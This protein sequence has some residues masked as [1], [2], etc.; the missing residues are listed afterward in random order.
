MTWCFW[1]PWIHIIWPGGRADKL[2]V[3]Y[4]LCLGVVSIS[5]CIITCKVVNRDWY[6]HFSWV[7]TSLAYCYR[8]S[9]NTGMQI[10]FFG[11]NLTLH[12]NLVHSIFWNKFQKQRYK[13]TIHLDYHVF[14]NAKYYFPYFMI[15]ILPS[16][17]CLDALEVLSWLESVSLVHL[18]SCKPV[19]F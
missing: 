18:I 15:L 11:S 19:F 16:G 2:H 1:Q 5:V 10:Q 8:I 4:P 9:I 3:V 17:D 13:N 6:T 7:E 14:F 12:F